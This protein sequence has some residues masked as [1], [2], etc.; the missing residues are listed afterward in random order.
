L[1]VNVVVFT[2]KMLAPS[3][4]MVSLIARFTLKRGNVGEIDTLESA[5]CTDAVVPR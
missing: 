1:N 2:A 3:E 5:L 4:R